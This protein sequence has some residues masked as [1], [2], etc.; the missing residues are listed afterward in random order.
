MK[1][2]VS[3]APEPT[4]DLPLADELAAVSARMAG[5]LLSHDTVES[6]L[7]LISSLAHETVA[8]SSGAGVTVLDD[9]RMRSSGST[10]ERVRRADSLQYEL[11]QG[12]CLA[13]ALERR[14]VRVDDL[15]EDR[16]WPQWSD[17]AARLGLRSSMSAPVVAGD[18]SLG[19]IKVYADDAH[20][21]DGRSEQLLGLFAAQAAVL[22]AHLRGAERG[23]QMSDGLRQAIHSRDVIS[24]AKGVL[25]GRHGIDEDA[26]LGMLLARQEQDG[27][28]VAGIAAGIVESA[29]RRRR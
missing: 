29:V 28:T 10:D 4:H 24:M 26:A 1:D 20:A 2:L 7:G 11:D 8:G 22:V 21:F 12:P 17:A 19:A 23:E 13:A 5:L 15:A 27:S 25:M 6:S 3:S 9:R 16:R 14:L 18:Q